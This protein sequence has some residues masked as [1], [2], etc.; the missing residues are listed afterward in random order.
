M[1]KKLLSLLLLFVFFGINSSS[2]YSQQNYY[3]EIDFTKNGI[4][5]KN[6]LAVKII[7]THTNFLSY[8]PG[9]W[10]ASKIT[11]V[12][13]NNSSQVLLIYGYSSTGITSRTRGIN[14]NGGNVGDWNREH[15]YPRSLGNPNLGEIGPGADAHH[16]RPSDVQFNGQ[17]GNKKFT[18]G[19]GNSRDISGNWFPGDEWKGDVARMMMYMYLHYGDRCLPSAVGIGNSSKTPDDMIDLFLKWNAEDPVSEIEDARNN[20]HGNPN[21]TYAQGNRNPFIDNP[22]LATKIWGNPPSGT[23][24]PQ[25]RWGTLSI[26]KN[27]MSQFTFYPNPAEGNSLF[28]KTTETVTVQIFTILGKQIL[29]QKIDE[30]TSQMDITSL[31]SGIY[32]VKISSSKISITKK[33]IKK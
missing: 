14:E 3:N 30:S 23:Q 16:L 28:F 1:I 20:Y 22:F 4:A 9:V 5:L 11:D 18:D 24:Q 10:E 21:N 13:P 19:S 33:L 32:L 29:S 6:D 7:N 27:D 17:R 25:D 26:S 8:T 31:K 2:Y 15:T 12:N